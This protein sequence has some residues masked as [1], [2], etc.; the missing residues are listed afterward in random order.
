MEAR[1]KGLV[2]DIQKFCVNDGP[3]IR[4]VVFLKGCNLRC[5]WCQNPES[6][7]P[8]LE[9]SY[10]E[11]YCIHCGAC[12][13]VCPHNAILSSPDLPTLNRELCQKCMACVQEC[14]TKALRTAG[15]WMTVEE[16]MEKVEED[17]VFYENS[18][19]GV[20]F[21]GGEPVVQFE[22]L[23]ALLQ[24]SGRRHLH[25]VLETN[26]HHPWE[27]LDKLLPG[28]ELVLFDIKHLENQVHQQ[29]TGAGNG[30]IRKNLELLAQKRVDWIPR[31]PLI[32]GV[33]DDSRHMDE[34]GCWVKGLGAKEIHL[35]PYHRLWDSKRRAFGYPREILLEQINPPFA[36]EIEEAAEV[37]RKVGLLVVIGG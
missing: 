33:N 22:F 3:G 11:N 7:L 2:F 1:E 13:K 26:G 30:L 17:R 35:L 20:T 31:V 19:G 29:Y 12:I 25:R 36:E 14:P 18:G 16:V 8:E 5:L 28:L 4:T 23:K 10:L 27:Q 24:E 32:P 6:I 15:Q 21:S 9:V 37:L 34:L